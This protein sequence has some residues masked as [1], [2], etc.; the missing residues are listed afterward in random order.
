MHKWLANG[1]TARLCL[2]HGLAAM[3]QFVFTPLVDSHIATLKTSLPG[4][5]KLVPH[6]PGSVCWNMDLSLLSLCW[7]SLA[8]LMQLKLHGSFSKLGEVEGF[9]RHP[10]C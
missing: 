6:I 7:Q 9:R 3:H 1:L 4:E 2:C 8:L 5:I 10:S